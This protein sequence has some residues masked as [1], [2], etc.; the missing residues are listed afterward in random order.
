MD[1]RNLQKKLNP[2]G[3]KNHKEMKHS[4]DKLS[5]KELEKENFR[6]SEN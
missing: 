1:V 5:H 4:Y 3:H 2:Q 6:D